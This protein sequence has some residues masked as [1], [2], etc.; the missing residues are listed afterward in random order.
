MPVLS[1]LADA[2]YSSCVG[3]F[4]STGVIFWYHGCVL[5]DAS[6]I[7]PPESIPDE[8]GG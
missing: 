4:I 2:C 1:S 7:Y 5:C 3:V 8:E 6:Y